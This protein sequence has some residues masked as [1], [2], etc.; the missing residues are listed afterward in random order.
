MRVVALIVLTAAAGVLAAEEVVLAADADA[1]VYWDER[2]PPD[3]EENLGDEPILRVNNWWSYYNWGENRSFIHFPFDGLDP[4]GS[5]LK[6]VLS[7]YIT[8]CRER[9]HPIYV[10][11][12]AEAW[13]EYEINWYNQ[14]PF[15]IYIGSWSDIFPIGQ[16]SDVVELDVEEMERMVRNPEEN[17]GIVLRTYVGGNSIIFSSR[18]GGNPPLLKLLVSGPAV[19]PA[20]WGKIKA[21][22]E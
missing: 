3:F 16:Y 21:S 19:Q 20:S 22:F 4:D 7:I 17:F 13:E 12:C 9:D 11:C 5:V 10:A 18:E 2:F 6:A 15:Y 1:Y 8:E 14:P